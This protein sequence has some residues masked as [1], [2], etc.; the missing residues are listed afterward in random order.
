MA[1]LQSYEGKGKG[2]PSVLYRCQPFINGKRVTIRL[3]AGQKRARKAFNAI[4]DLIESQRANTEPTAETR[5]WVKDT[6]DETL[7]RKL[8]EYGLLNRLPSRLS[9]ERDATKLTISQIA[10]EYIETRG[11]GQAAASITL[12]RKT[13]RNLIDCFGDIDIATMQVKHGREFWRWLLEEG[14]T[15]VEAGETKG[16]GSNTAKQR[17]RFARA[18]FEHAV[19]DGIIRKN[20][21]KARGLTTSQTAAEKQYVPWSVIEDVIAHCPTLEWKLLFALART[22]PTRVRSEIEELAWGD[23]DWANNT[24]LIHSPKTRKIG[25]SARLVPILP[26]LKPHLADAFDEA[27]EGETY[28][29]PTLRLNTNPGTSAKKVVTKAKQQVWP[30]FFNSLYRPKT[31]GRDLIKRL[32]KA[33]GNPSIAMCLTIALTASCVVQFGH[34]SYT[35]SPRCSMWPMFAKSSKFFSSMFASKNPK[36]VNRSVPATRLARAASWDEPLKCLHNAPLKS[37][38][39][40]I[41]AVGHSEQPTALSYMCRERGRYAPPPKAGTGAYFWA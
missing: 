27:E 12:Y 22:I 19:E 16:L 29:F 11:A 41:H 6:V 13:R 23:V 36:E 10:D 33:R 37:H 9:G 1:S 7:C 32:G 8:I 3:G 15:K 17:L 24:L 18:F 14:N 31:D 35:S 25:K 5:A 38:S 28:V 40:L 30:N 4:A 34:T 26:S 2:K 21:F 39:D 20:P